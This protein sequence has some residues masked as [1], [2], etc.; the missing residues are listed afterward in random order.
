MIFLSYNNKYYF[1][2]INSIVNA[3]AVSHTCRYCRLC[4]N[5]SRTKL[6][7][8]KEN[9]LFQEKSIE[10]DIFSVIVLQIDDKTR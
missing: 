6:I 8:R 4:Y 3:Q 9:Y 2:S 7:F 5:R 10:N 1:S